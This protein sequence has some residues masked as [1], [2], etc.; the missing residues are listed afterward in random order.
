MQYS[1]QYDSTC[2][3][4]CVVVCDVHACCGHVDMTTQYVHILCTHLEVPV[5]YVHVVQVCDSEGDGTN[6]LCSLCGMK[7]KIAS[8]S[9]RRTTN[10]ALVLNLRCTLHAVHVIH[11]A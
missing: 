10:C 8:L 9:L 6:N 3:A 2:A 7:Q 11:L 5:G 1:L 4:N